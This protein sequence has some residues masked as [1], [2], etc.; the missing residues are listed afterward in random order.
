MKTRSRQMALCWFCDYSLVLLGL[1]IVLIVGAFRWSKWNPA[2]EPVPF[3]V[4][5]IG[6]VTLVFSPTRAVATA[7]AYPTETPELITFTPTVAT[8][9]FAPEVASSG[10]PEYVL[11]FIPV[12]WADSADAFAEYAHQQADYYIRVSNMD[13][14]FYVK[15]EVLENG[16]TGVSLSDE[17]L[18]EKIVQ[19][20]LDNIPGNRYIGITD[21]DLAL[22][23]SSDVS[24]WT[25]GPDSIGLVAESGGV[26]IVAHELGHTFGLCDEYNYLYWTEQNAAFPDGCPNPYPL[27]CAQEASEEVMC[28]GS[29]SASGANSIMGPSGM[30]G[31][32]EFNRESYENL[33]RIFELYASQ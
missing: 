9:T 6:I 28:S 25:S 4:T 29:P 17:E 19:F 33:Q 1:L 11:V 7:A 18:V 2:L 30:L 15:V 8:P 14:Y 5:E 26:E 22:N 31:E 12:A 24:G 3:A 21:G 10:K 27:D 23:G 32:Y 13:Q 16:L 20:G